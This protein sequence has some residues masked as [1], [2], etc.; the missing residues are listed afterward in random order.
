MSFYRDGRHT[1]GRFIYSMILLNLSA[2]LGIFVAWPTYGEAIADP[3]SMVA[4]GGS[5]IRPS[6]FE[7]PFFLLWTVPLA[8]AFGAYM[9][10]GMD[11]RAAARFLCI[12]PVCM[13]L[14]GA[15][16]LFWSGQYF[17]H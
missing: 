6:A 2:S 10:K 8:C 12:F 1:G 11:M 4:S 5:T 3:V 7:Y 15:G 14:C 16:W 13:V 17:V 9:T